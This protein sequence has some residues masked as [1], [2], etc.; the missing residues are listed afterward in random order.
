MWYN[1]F[2]IGFMM[3][4]ASCGAQQAKLQTTPTPI[5]GHSKELPDG[6]DSIAKETP[7]IE[8][9]K[10]DTL[11][12]I[13]TESIDSIASSD[14]KKESP[15]IQDPYTE[16]PLLIDRILSHADSLLLHGD[17]DAARYYLERFIVLKPLWEEWQNQAQQQYELILQTQNK[18]AL[19]FKPLVLQISN[20]VSVGSSYDLVK[21]FTDSLIQMHPGDSLV[22][23]AQMQ[24]KITLQKNLKK[25]K[26]ELEHIL[27]SSQK[28]GEIKKAKEEVFKLK[29]RSYFLL[30]SIDF[31]SAILQLELFSKNIEENDKLYWKSHSPSKA[32]EEAKKQIEKQKFLEAKKMLFKLL[33][34]PLRSEAMQ[35]IERLSDTFCIMNRKKASELFLSSQKSKG[36]N[37]EQKIQNAIRLLEQCLEEFPNYTQKET[38]LDNKVFLES[39]L[40]K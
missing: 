15:V 29:S 14:N 12:Q 13:S 17:S 21:T 7:K 6:P 8:E 37:K 33:S 30:D 28:T 11:L 19:D 16:L 34:S 35:E 9:P 5:D 25:A 27:S 26:K 31:E 1:I 3:F 18:N 38:V 24:N 36:S 40:K 4:L 2:L 22:H 23:W 20:M 32:L 39:E 10:R